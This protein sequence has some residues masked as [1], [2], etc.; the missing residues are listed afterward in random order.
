MSNHFYLCA[1]QLLQTTLYHGGHLRGHC[2]FPLNLPPEGPLK[3]VGA[4]L[5][6]LKAVEDPP[7]PCTRAPI[8]QW[9]SEKSIRIIYMYADLCRQPDH[10]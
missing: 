1:L 3:F 2:A 7:P 6:E 5:Q 10:N 4:K 9:M 8:P